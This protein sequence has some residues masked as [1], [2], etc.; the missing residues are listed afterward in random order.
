MMTYLLFII[1]FYYKKPIF[2][3][4]YPSPTIVIYG[5]NNNYVRLSKFVDIKSFNTRDYSFKNTAMA[6][7][8][9]LPRVSLFSIGLVCVFIFNLNAFGSSCT[10]I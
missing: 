6:K 8:I 4:T 5:S 7:P 3:Y 2:T 10:R 9:N 1:L